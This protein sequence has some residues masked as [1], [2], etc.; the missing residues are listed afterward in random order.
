[1]AETVKLTAKA[2]INVAP[3]EDPDTGEQNPG[4]LREPGESYY[5]SETDARVHEQAKWADREG[6]EGVDEARFDIT[7]T[8]FQGRADSGDNIENQGGDGE[9]V[10]SEKVQSSE[11]P[12]GPYDEMTVAELQQEWKD[13][14]LKG[15]SGKSKEELVEGLQENDGNEPP[16]TQ[17]E[18]STEQAA[19]REAGVGQPSD[20]S[21]DV[22]VSSQED[23]VV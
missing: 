10:P 14:G 3:Y 16:K 2:R 5:A 21:A 19:L 7:Q 23:G 9:P 18:D 22:E 13:Q 4:G 20:V 17:Y 8:Q 12:S 15:Y 6:T 1:M 11:A